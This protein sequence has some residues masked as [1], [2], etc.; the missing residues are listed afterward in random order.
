MNALPV[1]W[2]AAA[3][4]LGQIALAYLL[5][6][7]I[8]WDREASDRSAG[9]RTFPLVAVGACSYML[10][11]LHVFGAAEPRARVL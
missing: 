4:H 6:M 2:G 11:A 10:I 3:A 7:P 5:A 8:G 1:D 9:L